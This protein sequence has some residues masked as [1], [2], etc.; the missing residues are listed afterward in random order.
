MMT[1]VRSRMGRVAVTR[2]DIERGLRHLGL[3][4]SD[5]VEVH[6][7]LSAFGRVEGGAAAVVDALIHVVGEEGTLVMSAQ[8]LSK[9]LPLTEEEKEKGILAKVRLYDEDYDGPT[10]MGVIADEFRRRPGVVLGQV[11]NRVC[12]WGRDAERHAEGYHTLIEVDG[13]VLCLGVDIHRCSS[14]HQAEK[15]GIPK[16]ITRRFAVPD[17]VRRAYPEDVYYIQYGST[18]GDAWGKAQDEA[19]R[20]GLIRRHRIGDAACMLFSASQVVGIYERA[21]RTD[22]FGLFEVEKELV[23]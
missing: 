21:L 13:L 23:C 14:M 16:E 19:E 2:I 22:P 7:S 12:A 8:S 5:A 20:R 18:P 10:G 15:V 1:S 11:P 9:P 3:A 6:S 4:R 17:D